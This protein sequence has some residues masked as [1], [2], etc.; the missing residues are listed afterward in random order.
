MSEFG[1]SE[2]EPRIE[3]TLSDRGINMSFWKRVFGGQS[4]SVREEE[5]MTVHQPQ[6]GGSMPWYVASS[7]KPR[8]E[9]LVLD[10]GALDF[11]DEP[12]M[13]ML[14]A[15]YLRV[16]QS[17]WIS[18]LL[19]LDGAERPVILV[20]ANESTSSLKSQPLKI[21]FSFIKGEA[22]NMF[23]LFVEF[24]GPAPFNC[25]TKPLVFFEDIQGLDHAENR[26]RLRAQLDADRFDVWLAEGGSA[27]VVGDVMSA[28]SIDVKYTASLA[29][30]PACRAKLKE[31]V[32][33]HFTEHLRI[34]P[35]GWNFKR[36]SE[37]FMHDLPVSAPPILTDPNATRSAPARSRPGDAKPAVWVDP[38]A[39]REAAH[40]VLFFRGEIPGQG[41]M[42]TRTKD[43]IF[44]KAEQ[45]GVVITTSTQFHAY[46]N[47]PDNVNSVQQGKPI[48]LIAT[49]EVAAKSGEGMAMVDR[50][51][52]GKSPTAEFYCPKQGFLSKTPDCGVVII[53][54]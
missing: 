38:E 16:Y 12:R 3:R 25:P 45:L 26:D 11:R 49:M 51:T 36:S 4:K 31:L 15:L 50:Y 14:T 19:K 52:S 34:G 2:G 39:E 43:V 33:Q 29:I 54:R 23:A 32:E 21:A 22:G 17:F 18:V 13:L 24:A 40:V 44:K 20:K 8:M 5:R 10:P 28:D 41:A 6:A 37:D 9:Q 30:E 47:S 48:A 7:R 42:P 27:K 53:C 1:L 35:Q 46:R